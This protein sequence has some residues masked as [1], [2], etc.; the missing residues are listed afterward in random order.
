MVTLTLGP[1][2]SPALQFTLLFPC[3]TATYIF[4]IS[5]KCHLIVFPLYA[6]LPHFLRKIAAARSL[7]LRS[8]QEEWTGR[9]MNPWCY[10]FG[11]LQPCLG[12]DTHLIF[13]KDLA[14][15]TPLSFHTLL[16]LLSRHGMERKAGWH[17]PYLCYLIWFTWQKV[18]RGQGI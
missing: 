7:L 13:W 14:V 15:E 5:K 12:K 1:S 16:S 9:T 18:L 4:R 2:P 17:V 11:D 10:V 3:I 6:C 8:E